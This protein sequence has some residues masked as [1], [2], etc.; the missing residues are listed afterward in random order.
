MN[1]PKVSILVPIYGVEKFIARCAESLFKQTYKNIEY[2]FV[3]DCTNDRSIII[4]KD[5]IRKYPERSKQVCIVN[6]KCNRGLAAARNTAVNE[7]TGDFVMHVDSD[8]YVDERI[9]EKAINRQTGNDADIVVIDFIRAYPSYSKIFRYS[10]FEHSKDYCLSVLSRN[11]SN[12]IW[13]KLIRRSLYTDYGITC[14]EGCN[15]GEDFQVVP[16]L[17]YHAKTII[18]LQEPLYFYDCSNISSYS[19]S[20]SIKKYEQ[21][22]ESMNIVQDY[23]NNENKEYLYAIKDGRIRQLVDDFIVS[24]KTKDAVS[25]FYYTNA[26]KELSRI[27]TEHWKSVPIL[28]RIILYLSGNYQLMK[29]YI[30][31]MRTLRHKML[32]YFSMHKTN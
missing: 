7:A 1:K 22:W 12:S 13:A 3:N 11:N 14:K 18:N 6:H 5:I 4:L 25:D 28:K 17:L 8:D 15:Q 29:V 30:I 21:N 10:S 32:T 9:V 16:L 27:K 23:F 20:F 2:V 19:N 24:A 26:R 31:I